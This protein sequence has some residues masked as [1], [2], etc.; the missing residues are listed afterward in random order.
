MADEES[1]AE[2]LDRELLELL[3]EL[4]VLLPGVQVLFAFLLTAPFSQRFAQ[5]APALQE[6]YFGAV[7]CAAAATLFLVA[8]SVHHRLQWRDRDKERLLKTANRL[9][10][11]GT[12]C[13]AVAIVLALWV[14]SRVLHSPGPAFLVAGGALVAF[15]WIWFALPLFRHLR[16]PQGGAAE[17]AE[18]DGTAAEVR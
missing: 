6:A 4:R 10:I 9:T 14:V 18:S 8:P 1:K 11:I 15:A 17:P 12:V 13:L 2:Q 3:N 5:L 7:L 16:R